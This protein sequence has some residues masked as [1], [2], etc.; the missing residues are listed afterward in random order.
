MDQA[1][2]SDLAWQAN[3][4]IYTQIVHHPFN[5]ELLNGS[6]DSNIF[7]YYIEQDSIYLKDYAKTLAAIAAKLSNPAEIIKFIDFARGAIVAEQDGVHDY[8][9]QIMA[10]LPTNKVSVACIGYTSYLLKCAFS[11]SI[12]VAIAAIV[13]CFWVYNEVGKH[14]SQS[15]GQN[16]KYQRWIDTY[17]SESFSASVEDVL[18]IANNYYAAANRSTQE[19]MLEAFATSMMWE[20]HFWDDAYRHNYFA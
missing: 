16:N 8:F 15:A 18:K 1:K 20:Y 6:L 10:I 7:S 2:F 5:Q 13:P 14:I 19:S 3:Q 17:A 12:E 9:R 4:D 11:E